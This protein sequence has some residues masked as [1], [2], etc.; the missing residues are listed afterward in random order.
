MLLAHRVEFYVLYDER[1][2]NALRTI[3]R[4]I[5]TMGLFLKYTIKNP[6]FFLYFIFH[7]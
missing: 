5:K 1:K 3:H 6:D 7:I 4:E 2:I